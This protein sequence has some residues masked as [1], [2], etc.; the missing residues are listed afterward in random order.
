MKIKELFSDQSKWTKKTAAR[1]ASGTP[2]SPSDSD[3]VCWCLAGGVAKCYPGE[4][5][6]KVHDA[7]VEKLSGSA[8][9]YG[10]GSAYGDWND[11][12]SFEEVKALVEQLDI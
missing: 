11:R 9:G 6:Y 7:I 3:A 5:R 8:Q 2:V 10:Y 4:E 12:A 1:D